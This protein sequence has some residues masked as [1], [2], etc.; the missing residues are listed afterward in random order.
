M[1]Y[2]YHWLSSWLAAGRLISHSCCYK[3]ELTRSEL[4]S[5]GPVPEFHQLGRACSGW[6]TASSVSSISRQGSKGF[7]INH[8][9]FLSSLRRDLWDSASCRISSPWWKG[10]PSSTETSCRGFA[11]SP[12]PAAIRPPDGSS[13]AIFSR[14]S[15]VKRVF[16]LTLGSALRR[17]GSW[18]SFWRGSSGGISRAALRTTAETRFASRRPD[19]CRWMDL[20]IQCLALSRCRLN[21]GR[22]VSICLLVVGCSIPPSSCSPMSSA[23]VSHH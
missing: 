11:S 17:P 14:S 6:S 23:P 22:P 8:S 2:E 15:W 18:G 9:L 5:P 19:A 4:S 7:F 1:T 20:Y 16:F 10:P 12:S 3:V 21:G 13:W